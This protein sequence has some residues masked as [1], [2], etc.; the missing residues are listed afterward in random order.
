MTTMCSL[1]QRLPDDF[2]TI[3]AILTGVVRGNSNRY[4]TKHLAEIFQPI[5]ESRPCCIGDG[6][7]QFRVF[8]HVS[9]LQVLIG[10]Q[11]VRLDYAGEPTS[12]QNLYAAN[13]EACALAP[14]LPSGVFDSDGFSMQLYFSSL[15]ESEKVS[16]STV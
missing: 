9:H 15:W 7:R 13:R 12:P 11:V 4:H 3:G 14:H 2:P 16:C 1:T 5:A 10:N 6:L 8:D